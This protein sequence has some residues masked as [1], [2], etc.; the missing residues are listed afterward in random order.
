MRRYNAMPFLRCVILRQV[1]KETGKPLWKRE[2]W[3][4]FVPWF[5]VYLQ[6]YKRRWRQLL[7][8]W[9]WA[10]NWSHNYSAWASCK[11]W[12]PWQQVPKWRCNAIQQLPSETWVQKVWHSAMMIGRLYITLLINILC[13]V[14]KDYSP[15]VDVWTSP[16]DGLRYF[17]IRFLDEN[18][19]VALQH[20][21][22]W[23]IEQFLEGNGGS[24]DFAWK[25]KRKVS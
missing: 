19:S 25:G 6:V 5:I 20:I 11:F 12:C 21:G 4:V 8:F 23:T 2:R 18:Q 22:V 14:A 24:N 1:L 9:R 3:N 17:L 16:A 10:T 15:F 7:L 13:R